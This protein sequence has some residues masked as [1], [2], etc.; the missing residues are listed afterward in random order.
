[1]LVNKPVT[2][3]PK[4]PSSYRAALLE[5]RAIHVLNSFAKWI[6]KKNLILLFALQPQVILDNCKQNI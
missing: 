4:S 6:K 1:M 2:L 5:L 3:G